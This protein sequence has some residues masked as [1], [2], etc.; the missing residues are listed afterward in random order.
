MWFEI[1]SRRGVVLRYQTGAQQ[2]IQDG[3]GRISGVVVR[4][5]DGITRLDAG[6]VVLAC[7]GFEANPEW[8]ARYLQRPWDMARVRGTAYNTGDGLRMALELGALPFGQ[9]SGNHGT[10]IDADAPPFGDRHLTDKTNRL[11]Y[12]LGVMV[13]TDG[14]RFIDEGEDFQLYTYAKTGG[15]ILCQPGNVAYQIFDAK[16]TSLLE[17]RYV[18]G[19]PLVADTL[20]EL[21]DKLPVGKTRLKGSLAAYNAAVGEAPFDPTVHD[22]LET[23]G[24]TPSKSNW[25]QALDTPPFR[26]YP[27]TGGI[28]FT[29]GGLRIDQ[30][31]QV[32]ASDWTPIEGLYTC[33]EMVGGLFHHNYPGG[34]GLTSGA[35][36][37]RIAGRSAA[38]SA[39]P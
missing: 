1:A 8:R 33:G 17:P 28:T 4:D 3:S 10:P 31:A 32:L 2:L 13:N 21:I 14:D 36:F 9:W 5:P 18:T 39:L 19:D 37:G 16:V 29:F 6:S 11:S 22:G 27:V 38:E 34:S 15:A 12:P 30:N 24:L 26:A 7:G 23:K 25:A 20:D 35:V